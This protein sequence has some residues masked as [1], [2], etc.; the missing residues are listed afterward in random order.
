[1]SPI[2]GSLRRC[3][4]I[5]AS[6]GPSLSKHVGLEGKPRGHHVCVAHVHVC[7]CFMTSGL[8]GSL[9]SREHAM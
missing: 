2:P 1:M 7:F 4:D 3:P 9:I 8:V 6:D 5:P